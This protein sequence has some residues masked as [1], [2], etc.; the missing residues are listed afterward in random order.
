MPFG[1]AQVVVTGHGGGSFLSGVGATAAAPG[2]LAIVIRTIGSIIATVCTRPVG[3]GVT[4]LL[5]ADMR[6]RKEG[7]DLLLQQA[8]QTQC[9]ERGPVLDALAAE[10]RPGTGQPGT[11]GAAWSRRLPG[12]G[13]GNQGAGQT[14]W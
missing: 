8:G 6:M 11:G 1:I 14:G 12:Q 5:Y 13:G 3:A 2:V 9:D 4:V 7:M 10:Q